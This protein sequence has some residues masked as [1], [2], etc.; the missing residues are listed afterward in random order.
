[1]LL[2]TPMS[3]ASFMGPE[4][5]EYPIGRSRIKISD[6]GLVNTAGAEWMES[7][8]RNT[9]VSTDETLLVDMTD[10]AADPARS[11]VLMPT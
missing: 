1:M 11:W 7:K 6:F 5:S 3:K 4:A 2:V 8:A 9:V 10:P